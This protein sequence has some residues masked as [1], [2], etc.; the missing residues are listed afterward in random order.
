MEEGGRCYV[1]NTL[2]NAPKISHEVRVK[3]S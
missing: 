3:S 1:G 2:R